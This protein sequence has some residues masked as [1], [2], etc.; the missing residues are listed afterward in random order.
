MAHCQTSLKFHA[1]PT[2][3]DENITS[4]AEVIIKYFLWRQRVTNIGATFPISSAGWFDRS[5]AARR[6][7][8]ALY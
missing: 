1:D 6:F 2:N 8:D 3:N 7:S 4:L 5:P